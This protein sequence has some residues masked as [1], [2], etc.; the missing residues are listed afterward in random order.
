[1]TY[2]IRPI[3]VVESSLV[4][5]ASAPKQGVEGAPDAWLAFDPAVAA[6]IG[7]LTIG[8]D[9]F[10]LTWL[11]LADRS[12]MAVHPRDD[13][14]TP[15]TGVF[16]TRSSDRPNPI[17]LHRVRVLAVDGLR[18]RVSDLEAVDGTPVIDLKPVLDATR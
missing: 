4:D 11:H 12:T 5:P 6:G 10:V 16:S 13:P 2:E 1:M 8:D 3:G 7:D 17:G 18:V 9:V 15:L 14:R